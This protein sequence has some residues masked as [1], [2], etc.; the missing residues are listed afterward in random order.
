MAAEPFRETARA[1]CMW[2]VLG[3]MRLH[4]SYSFRTLPVSNCVVI[5]EKARLA[6]LHRFVLQLHSTSSAILVVLSVG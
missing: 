1:T 4:P 3:A 6:K 5:R 2:L